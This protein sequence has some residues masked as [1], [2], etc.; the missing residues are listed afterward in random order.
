MLAATLKNFVPEQMFEEF[1]L[2]SLGFEH[3][4][5]LS[6]EELLDT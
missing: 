2:C 1:S 3:P 4:A 6:E 5:P